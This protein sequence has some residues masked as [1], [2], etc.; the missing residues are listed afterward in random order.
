MKNQVTL[1]AL[2]LFLVFGALQLAH[3]QYPA[4][5]SPP[6][7][8]AFASAVVGARMTAAQDSVSALSNTW[9]SGAP[10]PTARQGI[11]TGFIQG[12]MYVVGGAT[13]TA[14]SSVTEIYN[15][16]TNLWTT[17]ASM[18]TPRFVPASAVVTNILYVIGGQSGS[19]V[20][21][22]VEAYDPVSNK[23]STKAPMP[24]ARD[25]VSA[26]VENGI[27]YVV[28]GFSPSG[29]RLTTV[30]SYD[31]VANAWSTKAPLKVGKS[32]S[33]QGLLGSTIVAA[34]GLSNAG[35]VADNEG[36]NAHTNKWTTLTP[37]PTARHGGCAWGIK[38]QLYFAA[39]IAGTNGSPLNI[40]QAYSQKNNAW[41][42]LAVI[43]KP[44]TN[45]G[46]AS[47]G[48]RLYCFGGSDDGRLFQGHVFSDV[49]I[50]Q[51]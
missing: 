48:G 29:G 33:A 35:V 7:R 21:N 11:A 30:E 14:V 34:G 41:T 43:P 3:A 47:V 12:K 28:G 13:N 5:Q 50:Y 40:L 17:G 24:T 39:G 20:L 38:G 10:M 1:S 44:I 51:P 49:Q 32:T 16:S 22:V 45:P 19:G 36:Y 46:S 23:W 15:P 8:F 31:P 42:S 6:L 2:I 25:S 27:V 9:S 26:V 4:A 37:A 18:P